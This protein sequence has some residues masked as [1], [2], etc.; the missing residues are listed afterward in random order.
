VIIF[1]PSVSLPQVCSLPTSRGSLEYALVEAEHNA[2]ADGGSCA[3]IGTLELKSVAE[4][5]PLAAD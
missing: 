5:T 2:T 3:W 1:P 4:Q